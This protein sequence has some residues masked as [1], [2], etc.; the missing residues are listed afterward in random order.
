MSAGFANSLRARTGDIVLAEA[1]PGS[2]R[3]RVEMPEVWDA[4]RVVAGPAEPVLTV[5]VKALDALFPAA[6]FHQEFVVKF[7]G[8][9]ILDESV[10]LADAGVVDGS[11]LLVTYRRRRPVR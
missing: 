1:G 8:W 2:I 11:I 5:K 10:T 7:R 9:E 6:E 4:V 3:V